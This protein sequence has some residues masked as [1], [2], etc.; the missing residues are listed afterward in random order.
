MD[1]LTT[2]MKIK[3][4]RSEVFEAFVEPARLANFWFTFSA[5]RWESHATI[6]LG[7]E[8]FNTPPFDIHL[9]EL[10]PAEKIVFAWGDEADGERLVTI[11]MEDLDGETVIVGVKEEGYREDLPG[12]IDVLV[13]SKGG[14]TF[15]LTC[16][17]AYLEN[18]VTTLKLGLLIENEGNPGKS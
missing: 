11:T 5:R 18:G 6:A 14:W 15:M 8:E 9:K 10:I 12:T 16:L 4:T 3:T 13:D 2:R 1:H 7:Y 17:K